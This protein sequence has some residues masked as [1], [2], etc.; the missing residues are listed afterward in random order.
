[1]N[2][3]NNNDRIYSQS[4]KQQVASNSSQNPFALFK[5]QVASNSSQNQLALFNQQIAPNV[6]QQSCP[7]ILSLNWSIR[8]RI[9]Q[10][11]NG[12]SRLL[13]SQTID[14]EELKRQLTKEFRVDDLISAL[15]NLPMKCSKN[16]P[17][18]KSTS[19][20]ETD[21]RLLIEPTI[22]LSS[23]FRMDL[24]G[25]LI[26]NRDCG[27]LYNDQMTNEFKKNLAAQNNSTVFQLMNLPVETVLERPTVAKEMSGLFFCIDLFQNSAQLINLNFFFIR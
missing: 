15:S 19:S 3:S 13:F 2:P 25:K 27:I 21:D 20:T 14:H 6:N 9:I 8:D 18:N 22:D 5:Q 7:M 1:M 10:C 23:E 16:G 24:I 4:N 11:F 26:Q 17:N 12:C